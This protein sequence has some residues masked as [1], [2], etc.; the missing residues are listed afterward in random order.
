M[1]GHWFCSR[2]LKAEYLWF[3]IKYQ[4]R[5]TAHDN[6]FLRLKPDPGLIVLDEK[7]LQERQAQCNISLQANNDYYC[8]DI[9]FTATNVFM[10][11]W[12]E[13]DEEKTTAMKENATE[14]STLLTINKWLKLQRGESASMILSQNY[15]DEIIIDWHPNPPSNASDNNCNK[16][17]IWNQTDNSIHPTDCG[18]K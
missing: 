13:D 9:F 8:T 10:D 14:T 17:T 12:F 3:R 7:I 1:L 11:E 15:N 18:P 6:G 4:K 5:G 16:E 2:G